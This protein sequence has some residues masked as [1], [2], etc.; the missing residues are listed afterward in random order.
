MS[1]VANFINKLV[2]YCKDN[3][4]YLILSGVLIFVLVEIFLIK[5]GGLATIP[6]WLLDLKYLIVAAIVVGG[7]AITLAINYVFRKGWSPQKIFLTF[8]IPI[9]FLLMIFFPVGRVP[10]EYFHFARAYGVSQGQLVA[11]LKEQGMG[12]SEFSENVMKAIHWE[13][14]LTYSQYLEN[15]KYVV[16]DGDVKNFERY[17]NTAQYPFLTYLPQATG[18]KVASAMGLPVLWM[19]LFGR[20]FNFAAWA[21][22]M[23]FAIKLIPFKKLSVLF[24]VF[25]PMMLQESISLS[26]D[27]LVN[28][29]AF[30]LISYVLH[31][32]YSVDRLINIKDWSILSILV[33]LVSVCKIVY[34]PICL[35]VFLIPKERFKSKKVK[36]IGIG[37]LAVVV[38]LIT[39]L[40]IMASIKYQLRPDD[41]VNAPAQI[42]YSLNAPLEVAKTVIRTLANN[43]YIFIE[44]ISCNQL[45]WEDIPMDS[46]CPAI[47]TIMLVLIGVLD[48]TKTK[49]KK[50]DKL[51]MG[52]ITFLVVALVFAAEY[53]T[54]TPVGGAG[55]DGIQGR[56]FIPILIPIFVMVNVSTLKFDLSKIFR[57]IFLILIAIDFYAIITVFFAHVLG[58]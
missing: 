25:M 29:A 57:Y 37:V 38:V 52:I 35:V 41:G 42:K 18:I 45:G 3:I 40:W 44:N 47:M 8:V 50:Y 32:R 20:L 31:L 7:I 34:M 24:F 15:F 14:D 4:K 39:M 49:I 22:L 51:C 9:G 13:R 53:L 11:D 6:Q 1:G 58:T 30:L 21:V 48:V 43:L 16:N 46:W 5:L 12:G 17:T 26:A 56:Y 54:W 33:I 36:Y 27:P 2:K 19:A 55:V 10:D 23:F 28:G